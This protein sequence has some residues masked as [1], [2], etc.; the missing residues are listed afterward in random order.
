MAVLISVVVATFNPFQVNVL[1][2]DT[3][4]SQY[5]DNCNRF[6]LTILS[7]ALW[8]EVKTKRIYANFCVFVMEYDLYCNVDCQTI[9]DFESIIVH[10]APSLLPK[11]VQLAGERPTM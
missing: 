6:R 7:L 11:T 5:P 9:P 2:R 10:N 3:T 4:S 8:S 1:P